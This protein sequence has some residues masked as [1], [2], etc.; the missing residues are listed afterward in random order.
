LVDAA[1]EG[2]HHGVEI[3]TYP[4]AEQRDVVTGVTDDRDVCDRGELGAAWTCIVVERDEKSAQ[5]SGATD[6]T[7]KRDDAS[8]ALEI[9]RRGL[10]RVAAVVHV[11]R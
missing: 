6:A 3:W 10:W 9:A 7:S 11:T 4:K 2:V 5:E 1:A 8:T